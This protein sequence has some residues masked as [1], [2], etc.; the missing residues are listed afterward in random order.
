VNEFGFKGCKAPPGHP[1]FPGYAA[2]WERKKTKQCEKK[3]RVA[4]EKKEIL[5]INRKKKQVNVS[6]K[7]KSS[8]S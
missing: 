5:R 2:S 7:K 8:N 3:E 6:L 1:R 4:R